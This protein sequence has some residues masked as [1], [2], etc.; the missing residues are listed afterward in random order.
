MLINKR[1][2][3]IGLSLL[4]LFAKIKAFIVDAFIFT[5]RMW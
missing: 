5:I 3:D 1:E 4:F 2:T